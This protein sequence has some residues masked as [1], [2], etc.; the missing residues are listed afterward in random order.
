MANVAEKNEKK[1]SKEYQLNWTF[2]WQKPGNNLGGEDNH[3]LF[4]CI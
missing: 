1:G 3:E 2:S 4:K